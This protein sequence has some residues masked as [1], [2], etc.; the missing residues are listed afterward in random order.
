ML[1]F[2]GDDAHIDDSHIDDSHID[3]PRMRTGTEKGPVDPGGW[4]CTIGKK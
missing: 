4:Q 3:D 2:I 1:S